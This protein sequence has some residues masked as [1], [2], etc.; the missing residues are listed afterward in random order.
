MIAGPRAD[1]ARA[2]L[3]PRFPILPEPPA[4][5]PQKKHQA[6][7]LKDHGLWPTMGLDLD[8]LPL[9]WKDMVLLWADVAQLVEQRIRN[10]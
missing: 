7:S 4:R 6:D 1:L 8:T 9:F 10:A 2:E 5:Q 3:Y